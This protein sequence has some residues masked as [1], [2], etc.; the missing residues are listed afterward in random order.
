M[1]TA[2]QVRHTPEELLAISDRL[3]PELIDGKFVEREPLGMRR[4]ALV[5]TISRRNFL[6]GQFF[7]QFLRGQLEELPEA[8]VGQLQSQQAVWR[9][10]LAAAGPEPTQV[11]VQ[12]L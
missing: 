7:P 1:A 3:M 9:L 6:S 2:R 10:T 5:G 11:P 4:D 8:Q 12:S